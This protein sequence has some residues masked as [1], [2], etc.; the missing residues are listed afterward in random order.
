[1]R[2]S[3]THPLQIARVRPPG[4]TGEIGM[5][6][7]PGKVDPY[8]MSGEAWDRQ[9]DV[10]LDLIRNHKAT[11]LVTLLEN[12]EF[13]RLKVQGLGEATRLRGMAWLHLPIVDGGTPDKKFE[14][15]WFTAGKELHAELSGGALIVLHCRGGLGRTGIIAARLLMEK[16]VPVE[17]AIE[18]IRA[19]R[20]GAIEN[21]EQEDYLHQLPIQSFQ[22]PV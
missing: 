19:A 22:A 9:L 17:E 10:D 11:T 3:L 8:P 15:L 1:M 13:R 7:C 21:D 12:H 16:G 5:T 4:C 2:T 20:P 6:F 14:N 18:M